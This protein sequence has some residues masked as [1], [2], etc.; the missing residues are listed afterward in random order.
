MPA[1][2]VHGTK[3]GIRT[4]AVTF[5]Q[6]PLGVVDAPTDRLRVDDVCFQQENDD[7]VFV[8]E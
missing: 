8:M 1:Q 3:S 7:R 6:N 4:D 2:L 5:E